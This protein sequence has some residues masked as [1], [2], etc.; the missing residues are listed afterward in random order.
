MTD[1]VFGLSV[2][3][4]VQGCP[5]QVLDPRGTW[6]DG[7]AYDEAAAKLAGM[8]KANFE[9]FADQVSDEIRAAGPS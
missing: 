7:A 6:A 2:P 1:P 8:F 9:Q 5:D 3:T 4:S